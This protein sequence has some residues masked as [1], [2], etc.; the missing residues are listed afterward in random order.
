MFP[1]PRFLLHLLGRLLPLACAAVF[2]SCSRTPTYEVDYSYDLLQ[3][4]AGGGTSTY[5]PHCNIL[6]TAPQDGQREPKEG[7]MIR[8]ENIT[9]TNAV[10]HIAFPDGTRADLALSPK[11]SAVDEFEKHGDHGLRLAVDEIRLRK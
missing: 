7:P 6:R 2:A 9:P 3:R 5:G 4:A 10:F 11:A 8:V 1:G